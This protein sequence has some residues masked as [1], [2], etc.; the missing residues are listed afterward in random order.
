[1]LHEKRD[2]F[3][4]GLETKVFTQRYLPQA[5]PLDDPA[6]AE[7]KLGQ[8]LSMSSGLHREGGNRGFANGIGQKL[9]P[10]PPPDGPLDQDLSAPLTPLSTDHAAGNSYASDSPHLGSV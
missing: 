2:Q 4:E 1:M 8:L 5:K 3:P 6:K 7:I 10:L 9:D